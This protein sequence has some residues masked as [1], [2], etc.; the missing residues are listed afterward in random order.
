MAEDRLQLK[1]ITPDRLV[2]DKT[3][4]EVVASGELGEFGV[5]PGHVPF[6][7]TLTPG[8]LR[9]RDGSDTSTLILHSGVAE[10]NENVV[11][12]LVD[13]AEDPAKIDKE[14]AR[15]EYN[16]LEHE[17]RHGEIRSVEESEELLTK[18]KLARLRLG[19][20]YYEKPIS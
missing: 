2:I 1:V 4:D 9:F 19:S 18:L 6:I 5:L 14:A 7:T 15:K 16:E 10:V 20:E 12:I 11:N 17:I 3:V 13:E 8:E